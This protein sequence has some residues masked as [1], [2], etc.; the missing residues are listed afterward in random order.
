MLIVKTINI[1]EII[2]EPRKIYFELK[3]V[4][5]F[6]LTQLMADSSI[7]DQLTM[8]GLLSPA[9]RQEINK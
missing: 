3:R 5:R 2:Y 9:C 6:I 8:T 1:T 7:F 4:A